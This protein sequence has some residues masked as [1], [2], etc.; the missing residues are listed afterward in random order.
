VAA[1]GMS[2]GVR[3]VEGGETGDEGLLDVVQGGHGGA[4]IFV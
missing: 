3:G 2:G 1:R 4:R